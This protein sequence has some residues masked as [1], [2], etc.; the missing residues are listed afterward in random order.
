MTCRVCE[1]SSTVS[2]CL[3]FSES[4]WSSVLQSTNP[5]PGSRAPPSSPSNG[6]STILWGVMF[7]SAGENLTHFL[8]SPPGSPRQRWHPRK[9]RGSREGCEYLRMLCTARLLRGK[10]LVHNA[11]CCA[12]DQ[13]LTGGI[14]PFLKSSVFYAVQTQY[15]NQD[16]LRPFKMSRVWLLI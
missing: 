4:T 14:E 1:T 2:Q 6:S 3:I 9:S 13:F 15:Q 5:S 10:R 16:N 11:W 7:F 8:S 12:M